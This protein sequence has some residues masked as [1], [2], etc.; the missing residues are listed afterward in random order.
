MDETLTLISMYVLPTTP[1]SRFFTTTMSPIIEQQSGSP[2]I[3]INQNNIIVL[4]IS[5]AI[6]QLMFSTT[7]QSSQ[8]LSYNFH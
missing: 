2:N 3:T 8:A 5:S 7:F 6:G 1:G 4:E